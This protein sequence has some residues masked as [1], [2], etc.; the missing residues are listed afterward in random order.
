MNFS[1]LPQQKHVHAH[2][3]GVLLGVLALLTA[4]S[5]SLN[6]QAEMALK[7]AP[8]HTLTAE[9]QQ[10]FNEVYLEGTR[11]R[12]RGD[13]ASAYLLFEEA[14]RLNP[15]APEALYEMS[16][17]VR[18][19]AVSWEDTLLIERADS[20]LER[21]TVF[22]PQNR[23]FLLALADRY[24][25]REH[26]RDAIY[27]REE[28]Q[29]LRPADE[30]NLYSLTSLYIQANDYPGAI[31]TLDRLE[32]LYGATE[33]IALKKFELYAEMADSAR[34]FQALEDLCAQY[35]NDL[36]YRVLLGDAYARVGRGE[37][38]QYIYNDVLTTEPNNGFAQ[39]SLL[40]QALVEKNDTLYETMVHRLVLNPEA[41]DEARIEALKNY[42]ARHLKGDSTV[43]LQ[44]FEQVLAQRPTNRGFGDLCYAYMT[45]RN[46]PNA[47]KCRVLEHLLDL[48][49][50]HKPTR[51]QLIR[52]F[53]EDENPTRL[54]K[55]CLD[56]LQYDPAEATYYYY[57]A[58]TYLQ[59]H[60]TADALALL[61]RATE[62][63]APKADLSQLAELYLLKADLL[64][65]TGRR[66]EAYEAYD[67][68]ILYDSGNLLARNNYAYF[69]A[70]DGE[71]LDYAEKLSRRT[72]EAEPTNATFLDTYAWIL[73]RKKDYEQ[74]RTFIDSTL[75]HDPAPTATLYEHA[76]DIYSRCGRTAEA[77]QFWK[78]ALALA[79]SK[80]DRQRLQRK[81]RK[82]RL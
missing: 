32:R 75:R 74:A 81:V 17:L 11:Q 1:L 44:L 36:R 63:V 65:E 28:A 60:H 52:L 59:D 54:R 45:Q 67:S 27:Y 34:A 16:V 38:A 42:A 55:V 3:L 19:S 33:Q 37:M 23:T 66:K 4:C 69:L 46:M 39:L 26:Y 82:R 62:A 72:V 61:N 47:P 73:F 5:P 8:K 15:Y 10:R 64:H 70:E 24:A 43:M 22:M 53:I 20:L 12:L 21:A 13:N 31:S 51:F 2:L 79:S 50:E 78:K 58:L 6:R 68:V 76:G 35:P 40:N 41:D 14:L 9:K 29:K 7:N 18:E 71:R 57:P 49:P 25:D 30:D 77:V 56:G 48:A 80:A